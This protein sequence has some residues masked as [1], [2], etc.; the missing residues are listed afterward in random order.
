ML[1]YGSDVINGQLVA[2]RTRDA[3]APIGWG[4][5]I[6]GPGATVNTLPPMLAPGGGSGGFGVAAPSKLSGISGG[7]DGQLAHAGANNPWDWALS[8]VPILIAILII[9]MVWL[10]AVHWRP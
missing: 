8:P 7:A 2:V 6:H 10:R 4:P 3:Y 9:S 5:T 1:G